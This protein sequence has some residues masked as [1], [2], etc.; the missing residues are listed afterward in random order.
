MAVDTQ[1][2]DYQ[3]MAP[4][5]KIMRDTAGGQRKVHDAGEAYLP[6]LEGEK[7]ADYKARKA[8]ATFFNATRRTISGLRS[9]LFRK[10]PTITV[11]DGLKPYLEDVTM[12]GASLYVSVRDLARE[13]LTVGRVGL[14]VDHPMVVTEGMT[15]A[16]AEAVGLRP[17]MASY[18][19]EAIIN[20]RY[21]WTGNRYTLS[22]VVLCEDAMLPGKDEFECKHEKRWRVLDLTPAGYRQRVYRKNDKGEDEQVGGDIFP[23]M[24][25][26]PLQYIPYWFVGEDNPSCGMHDPALL[27]LANVNLSHYRSTAD[28]KHGAHKTSMPQPWIAGYILEKGEHLS[29]GGGDAWCFPNPET[30]AGMLEYTGQGLTTL[31]EEQER[32]EMQMAVLGARMLEQ[33]KKAQEAAETAAIH[34]TGENAT[35][36]DEAQAISKSVTEALTVFAQWASVSGTVAFELNRD[37]LPLPLSPEQLRELVASWQSGALS[38]EELFYNLQQGEVIRDSTDFETHQAAIATSG[39]RLLAPPVDGGAGAGGA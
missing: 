8:R 6:R 32:E 13:R 5:W 26:K 14:I 18:R 16:E 20:W 9:M 36:S 17:K 34:R 22:M 12:T 19:A 24:N 4:D 37:F 28:R 1:H 3:R 7:D 21:E 35:L 15:K 30:T 25:G 10:P 38:D 2:E 31:K 29:I 27:D 11:P 33:Q 39:P 23:L